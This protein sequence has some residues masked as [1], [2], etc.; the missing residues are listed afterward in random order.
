MRFALSRAG[1]A[2][3]AGIGSSLLRYAIA[4]RPS[5]RRRALSDGGQVVAGDRF[6]LRAAVLVARQDV[7]DVRRSA[8]EIDVKH[9]PA[10]VGGL[11][12]DEFV[13]GAAGVAVAPDR[14]F[15]HH[16]SS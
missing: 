1:A 10:A 3:A 16:G 13:P 7:D 8:V 4:Q 12:D 15:S 11:A 6:G 2:V 14:G 9:L 5:R